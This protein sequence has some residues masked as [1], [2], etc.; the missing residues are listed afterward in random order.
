MGWSG[1]TSLFLVESGTRLRTSINR[2]RRGMTSTPI[3][4]YYDTS[5]ESIMHVLSDFL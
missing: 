5:D 1:M 4:A 2:V 3:C